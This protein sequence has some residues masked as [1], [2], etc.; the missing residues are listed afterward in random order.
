MNTK[1]YT[2]EG[3]QDL[4]ELET[5]LFHLP[6][7]GFDSSCGRLKLSSAIDNNHKKTRCPNFQRLS[8]SKLG[9]EGVS[10][11][12]SIAENLKHGFQ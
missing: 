3:T 8:G 5:I 6:A 9:P 4:W 7:L 2:M 10:P 12:E 1:A 11:F